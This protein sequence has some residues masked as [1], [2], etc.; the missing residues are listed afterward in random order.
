MT[1][2]E[3]NEMLVNNEENNQETQMA[4]ATDSLVH[5]TEGVAPLYGKTEDDELNA[6]EVARTTYLCV[7]EPAC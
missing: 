7:A 3:Y 5:F 4:A 2:Y 1:A 6:V